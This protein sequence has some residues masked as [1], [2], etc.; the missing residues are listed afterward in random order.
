MNTPPR[1]IPIWVIE[2]ATTGMTEPTLSK[3][4]GGGQRDVTQ[5]LLAPTSAR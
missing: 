1:T 2:L 3:I 4:G 5:R